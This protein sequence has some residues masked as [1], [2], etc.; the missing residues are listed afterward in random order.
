MSK[1]KKY[2]V[3]F[4]ETMQN[5]FLDMNRIQK[6]FGLKRI[7]SIILLKA[8]LE[9]KNSILYDFLCATTISKNPYKNI[10]Q[11]CD[12][13]LKKLKKADCLDG[14]EKDFQIILPDNQ[15]TITS[16]LTVEV[17]NALVK[18]ISTSM[19]SDQFDEETEKDNKD[20][21]NNEILINSEDLLSIF[22]D[23]MPKE[24]LTILK[25]NGVYLDGLFDYFDLLDEIYN[26]NEV[27]GYENEV[28][29]N[30]EKLPKN[31]SDFVTVLSS[32]YKGVSECEILGRDKECRDTMRILQ[33]RGKKNVIL[34]GE[35]GVGKSSIAEKIAYDIANGNC[36]DSLK[37]NVV[38]QLNVNSS[39]AGTT[40]R[41]MAEERFKF[42]IEYLEKHENVILFIDEIHM[43]IGAGET[44][45]K[46]ENDMSNALKP[47]LASSK[48]K[49]IGATTEKEYNKIIATDSAFKRRFKKIVVKEPKSKDVYPM[50]KNAIKAHEKFHGVT[51]SKEMVEYAIL[52][53]ACFNNTTKNPDR[54]NDLIDT[55]MVI[56]K[57]KGLKEV[58]RECILEN[59]DIN[60]EKFKNMSI[61][62]KK[63]TAYHE[64]GHYLVWR[65]SSNIL[66]G[67]KGIA[68]SI[69]P[70]EGYLG[71]T[72]FD[73]MTDE[74][75]INPNRDYFIKSFASDLAGRIAEELFVLDVNS[76][77]SA[78][79]KN[80][81]KKAY[82]MICNYAMNNK[83][84]YLTFIEDNNYHM[85]N[86]KTIDYINQER[87]KLLKDASE[88]AK[89]I[90]NDNREL[91]DKL[92][93]ALLEKGILDENDLNEIF[94]K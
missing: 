80:A 34:V 1:E 83:D 63:A 10:I 39:I 50:L 31:L 89:S 68:V 21:E 81:N 15:D 78:D 91:L 52:I 59:F 30:S 22:A 44:S 53:S 48:A 12:Q 90:L 54:T 77:A 87:A 57:E 51:I 43:A 7:N 73:D 92:V 40:L 41:G 17:Y 49:V 70:A 26:L 76:G 72:V 65:L 93:N 36:P 8:L 20:E 2:E 69:M 88:Y 19:T 24:P 18:T 5:L 94:S 61:E 6:D 66:K 71:V 32:K 79:L 45:A 23:D 11:D 14:T 84:D 55:S 16:V 28:S 56:A 58:T 85:I 47:F 3:H 35:A 38:F 82:T 74:V 62:E 75:N 25:N 46:G 86:E 4:D 9:E 67:E 60:F 64:A 42:L 37:D 29:S 13:E 33:K 27:E